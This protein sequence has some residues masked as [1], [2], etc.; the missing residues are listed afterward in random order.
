MAEVLRT[1]AAILQSTGRA[2]D[3]EIEAILLNSLEITRHQRA[4]GVPAPW[5]YS[6]A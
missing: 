2:T 6:I 5:R 4:F 1:K 3:E